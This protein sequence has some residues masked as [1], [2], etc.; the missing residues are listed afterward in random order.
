MQTEFVKPTPF[1]TA[2]V[3]AAF[4]TA[5]LPLTARAQAPAPPIFPP[6]VPVAP[7]RPEPEPYAASE[8]PDYLG[9]IWEPASPF[10]FQRSDPTAAAPRTINCIV[11]HDIEGSAISAVRWFQN[12]QATAS[13][14]YVMGSDG[15]VYQMVKERDVAWHAGNRDIN[16]RSVGI[17]HDGFAYRPGFYNAQEYEGSAR[18][19]RSIALRYQIPRDRTHIFGHAEVPDPSDPTKFGGRSGHTDPGPYWDWDYFMALVRNDAVFVPSA[20]DQ[21]PVSVKL[22]PGEKGEAVLSFTN[23][24]DDAW[25][26]DT[27]PPR[28]NADLRQAGPVYLGAANAAGHGDGSPQP[29]WISPQFA[30]SSNTGDVPPNQTT[31]FVVPLIGGPGAGM[32]QNQSLRLWKVFPAPHVPVPFGPTVSATVSTIPW[33]ITAP[34]PAA[35][36]A[37]W[38]EK[39]LPGT[40]ERVFWRVS[41]LNE[42]IAKPKPGVVPPRMVF[43]SADL[44]KGGEWDVYVRVFPGQTALQAMYE[45]PLGDSRIASASVDKKAVPKKEPVWRKLGRYHFD[46]PPPLVSPPGVRPGAPGTTTPPS[47]TGA[48]MMLPYPQQSDSRGSVLVAGSVRFVGPFPAASAIP[49]ARSGR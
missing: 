1:F 35:P 26:A 17:E 18:L 10:N 24:G 23:T 14:H 37:G 27:K 48:A 41:P 44:P 12:K 47:V 19:V 33:D 6:A 4:S 20:A 7:V 28:P 34:L 8:T 29:G 22:H 15:R 13:S 39:I 42:A 30:A 32:E 40:N 2:V 16:T 9:A 3:I 38:N 49:A 11:I 21:T 5:A 31:R 36:P 25:P 45:I 43:W 46:A